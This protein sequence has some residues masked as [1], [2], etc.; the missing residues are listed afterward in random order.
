MARI[1]VAD[2]AVFMRMVVAEAIAQAG[3]EV[4]GEAC[5]GVEAVAR[6]RELRPDAM[7]L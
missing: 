4:V 5:N 2:D 1:L 3:H 7:T 6:Y